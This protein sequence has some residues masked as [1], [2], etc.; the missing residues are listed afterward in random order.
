M[1]TA[2]TAAS[3][4]TTGRA[5]CRAH[6]DVVFKLFVAISLSSLAGDAD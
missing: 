3:T 4:A 2:T 6:S 5:C 1:A